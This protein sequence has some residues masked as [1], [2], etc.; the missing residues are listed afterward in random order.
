MARATLLIALVVG[1]TGLP[2]PLVLI[3]AVSRVAISLMWYLAVLG[4]TYHNHGT[5]FFPRSPGEP[6]ARQSRTHHHDHER[7]ALRG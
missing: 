7:D 1:V 5:L 4:I 3:P 2:W 6:G